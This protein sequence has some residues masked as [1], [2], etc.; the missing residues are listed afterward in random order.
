MS[1]SVWTELATRRMRRRRA[2]LRTMM[3][4]L[5]QADRPPVYAQMN[6]EVPLLQM[7][8]DPQQ[9]LRPDYRLSRTSVTAL[10]QLLSRGKARGWA[11]HLEVLITLYWLAHG[12]SYSVVSRAFQV[13]KTTVHRV[14]HQLCGSLVAIRGQ[15]IRYPAE[16][17][18]P[19]VA[20]GFT[21]LSGSPA[22]TNCVGALDGCHIRIKTPPGPHGQDYINRKLFASVQMQALCDS[23]GRFINLFVGYPG[24]VHDTRVLKNSS[25]YTAAR[26]PPPGYF[27]IGDGGYPCIRAPIT[28]LTPYREPLQGRVQER[29][30]RHHARA[31]SVIER[32]FGMM[33]TR[34]RCLFFKALEVH[35]TFV[36]DVVTVC[37]VLHNICL[38]AGD[39]VDPD[40]DRPDAVEV[41]P[42][43]PVRNEQGGQGVRDR[44]AAQIS[45]PVG[46]PEG[47]QDHDYL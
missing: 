17:D 7:Y 15:H 43:R 10:L 38:T 8:F 40:D 46:Q 35:H 9:D 37:A 24:S 11:Q 3:V 14:V 34:W 26:Y 29:Y 5:E 41:P 12:L 13:P 21:E 42:P 23:Y 31:R 27:I 45:A 16:E 32:A 47:L 33:K 44:L 4:L 39:V 30:N 18:V 36:P 20:L 2:R 28:L 6:R 25:L 1:S 22:F 19:A